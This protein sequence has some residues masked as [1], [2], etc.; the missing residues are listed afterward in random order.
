M[1]YL[2]LNQIR[3][4]MSLFSCKLNLRN[5]NHHNIVI[6]PIPFSKLIVNGKIYKVSVTSQ[7]ESYCL[8]HLVCL[9]TNS[10]QPWI[11][12]HRIALHT[13]EPFST[14]MKS[15][16][17][18]NN[19]SKEHFWDPTKFSVVSFIKIGLFSQILARVIHLTKRRW[20]NLFGQVN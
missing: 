18:Q 20:P 13:N 3:K 6:G 8:Q 1:K 4:D 7:I 11:A 17:A 12:G 2:H 19:L 16:Q 9:L 15:F 14:H 5:N 10:F